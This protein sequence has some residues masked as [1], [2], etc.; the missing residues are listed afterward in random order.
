[1]LNGTFQLAQKAAQPR[2]L[3]LGRRLGY[4]G[5][6]K[7]GRTDFYVHILYGGGDVRFVGMPTAP[8][9]SAR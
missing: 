4:S 3:I 1:M 2:M 9:P 8:S 5:P 6:E 7:P